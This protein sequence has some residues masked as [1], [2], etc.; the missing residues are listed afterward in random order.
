MVEII[1]K[2]LDEKK[3]MNLPVSGNSMLPS[4]QTGDYVTLIKTESI[5]DI[6]CGDIIVY[7]YQKHIIMHRV[8]EICDQYLV[9]KGDNHIY[10][11]GCIIEWK[12]VIGKIKDIKEIDISQEKK[13]VFDNVSFIVWNRSQT[14]SSDIK[15]I[16]SSYYIKLKF[17]ESFDFNDESINI[18]VT[19][20]ANNNG[21]DLLEYL[22][23]S[24][25]KRPVNIHFNAMLS[26]FSQENYLSYENFDFICRIG[27]RIPSFLMSLN[28]NFFTTIGILQCVE[29]G[30][31]DKVF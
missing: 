13:L 31:N 21:Y 20:G 6:K 29:R 16:I 2:V 19:P 11:D 5:S 22:N 18:A 1:R 26:N 27:N 10:S 17:V 3:K 23:M 8:I 7:C 25:D 15:K 14:I 4:Y 24:F 30:K 12:D 28:S 9:T